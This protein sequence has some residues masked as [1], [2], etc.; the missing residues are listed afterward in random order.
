[1]KQFIILHLKLL[2][3]ILILSFLFAI[4][5]N[6]ELFLNTLLVKYYAISFLIPNKISI[7][8]NSDR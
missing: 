2:L 6:F 1:M 7:Y 3:P 4:L 5:Y 8:K